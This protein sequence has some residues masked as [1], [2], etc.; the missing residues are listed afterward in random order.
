VTLLRI[1]GIYANDRAGGSPQ[2]RVRRR[3][4][5]LA[6]D[7]DVY[8]NH[9]HADDLA[10]ACLSALVRGK[11]Q[12]VVHVSDDSELKMGDYFDRVADLSGL[13][14]PPRV[15]RSEAERLLS[16]MAY[17]FLT[18]SRRLVNGR[19]RDELRLRL[20]YPRVDDGLAAVAIGA[21]AL[22]PFPA[23]AR[24][25]AGSD[26]PGESGRHEKPAASAGH[27]KPAAS[28]GHDKPA[29]RGRDSR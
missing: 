18:E 5:V 2:D 20:R 1:P 17:S 6:T 14:R 10:R 24:E 19:L 9:I 28:A 3:T 11:P 21:A 22:P 23:H 15:G 12:R 8:S 26:Q 27:D 29:D 16:P 13:A 25:A 7:E 4:P